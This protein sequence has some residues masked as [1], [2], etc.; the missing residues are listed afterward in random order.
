MTEPEP[1]VYVVDDDASVRTSL[2]RLLRSAGLRAEPFED[3]D[4]ASEA[5]PDERGGNR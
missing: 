5:P 4:S 3:D 1:L 2:T